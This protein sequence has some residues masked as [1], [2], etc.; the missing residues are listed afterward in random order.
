MKLVLSIFLAT[1][2]LSTFG[3]A[4]NNTRDSR[5]ILATTT[6]VQDSGVLDALI[7]D[8]ESRN[9]E[10]NVKPIAVGSGEALA[11]GERG[12]ADLLLVHSPTDEKKFMD[13]GFGLNRTPLMYNH[14]IILGS[15]DDPAK[16]KGSAA[17]KAFKNIGESRS[18]F[19]SRS[20]GSGTHNKE[21]QL[22]KQVSIDPAR[23]GRYIQ[24]GQ[25]MAET[26]RIA[27]QKQGYTLSDT[28][29]FLALKDTISLVP[30]SKEDEALRNEYSVIEVNP[31]LQ[32]KV[33]KEGAR[34]LSSYLRTK[35]RQIIRSY[36]KDRFDKS[37]F[38]VLE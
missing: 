9:P 12:D 8:F 11:M 18:V 13:N 22:W 26:I 14:F 10:F 7:K 2:F 16:I 36:G 3:C 35:G 34:A 1:V 6:S 19:V 5:V 31:E 25:G 23:N 17:E 27:D 20:D 37:L 38:S 28:G 29:T 33:N 21:L 4:T 15:K 32:A 24:T 30:L